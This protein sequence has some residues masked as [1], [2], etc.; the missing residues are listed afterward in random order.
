MQRH[1]VNTHACKARRRLTRPARGKVGVSEVPG[2]RD[3]RTLLSNVGA[4]P[5]APMHSR[6]VDREGGS[7]MTLPLTASHVK[8]EPMPRRAPKPR[9]VRVR[10]PRE[11]HRKCQVHRGKEAHVGSFEQRRRLLKQT[12]KGPLTRVSHPTRQQAPNGVRNGC[13]H[14]AT[15]CLRLSSRTEKNSGCRENQM[16]SRLFGLDRGGEILFSWISP[17]A[18]IQPA[19]TP[20]HAGT[21]LVG[22]LPII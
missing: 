10:A 20:N 22:C 3:S 7:L 13:R 8:R 11:H 2:D 21:S 4:V 6:L 1:P 12:Q 18:Q 15:G 5:T 17:D 9:R 16:R 19:P 14:A